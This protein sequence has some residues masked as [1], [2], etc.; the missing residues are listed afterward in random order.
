MNPISIA[1]FLTGNWTRILVYAITAAAIV[2]TI[3]MHGYFHGK[4]KL[5][6]YQAAEAK[7]NTRVA[8]AREWVTTQVITR[9]V[10][11]AGQTQVVTN[12]V[13]KEVIKYAEAN[14]GSCL[15]PEFRRLHD[16][17]ARNELPSVRPDVPSGTT[18][19]PA[20]R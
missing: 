20:G 18:P 12:T 9:Y 19:A 5:Y 1:A 10:K 15:D 7:E 2:G 17:A 16:L 13:D 8:A 4:V 3:W 11:V 6:E 14:P